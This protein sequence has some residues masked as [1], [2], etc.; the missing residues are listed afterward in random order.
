MAWP[1][2]SRRGGGAIGK[3]ASLPGMRGTGLGHL[4]AIITVPRVGSLKVYAEVPCNL[5][6]YTGQII[7]HLFLFGQ[8]FSRTSHHARTPQQYL[9]RYVGNTP[10]PRG[11]VRMREIRAVRARRVLLEARVQVR[12]G[13]ETLP[14]TW[15]VE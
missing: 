11:R 5:H 3:K 7:V 15:S 2:V 4:F 9:L 10:K 8:R 1:R 13:R 14:T 6:T 12:M